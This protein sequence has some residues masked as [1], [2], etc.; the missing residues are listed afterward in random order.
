MLSSILLRLKFV[1]AK[2]EKIALYN[3]IIAKIEKKDECNKRTMA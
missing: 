1:L 2:T 3:M